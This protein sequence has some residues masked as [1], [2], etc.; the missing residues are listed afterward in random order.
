MFG[1]FFNI[2]LS[3]KSRS[4]K[5]PDYVG[6]IIKYL[7]EISY[8]YLKHIIELLP[9]YFEDQLGGINEWFFGGGIHQKETGNTRVVRKFSKNDFW[10]YIRYIILKFTYGKKGYRL[11]G[12]TQISDIGN[13]I[14]LIDRDVCWKTNL[15]KVSFILYHFKYVILHYFIHFLD[16]YLSYHLSI[17]YMF[18]VFP[19][20]KSSILRRYVHVPFPFN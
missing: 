19:S 12:E 11:L 7:K 13:N 6:S 20:K 18:T 1:F 3:R 5:Q 9:G 2:I 17:H 4:T 10:K 8:P 15:Q 16:V 14:C